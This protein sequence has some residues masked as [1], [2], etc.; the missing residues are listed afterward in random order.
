MKFIQPDSVLIC[1]TKEVD[2]RLLTALEKV[3][4]SRESDRDAERILRALEWFYFSNFDLRDIP[5]TA[6]IVMRAT[7]FES[8]L[9]ISG[10]ADF[11]KKVEKFVAHKARRFL[12]ESAIRFMS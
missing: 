12:D 1:G 4:E 7:A 10:T 11:V 8:L 2:Q 9:D 3:L 6:V 5:D